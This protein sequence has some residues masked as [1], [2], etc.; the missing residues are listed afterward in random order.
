M[1]AHRGRRWVRDEDFVAKS[2]CRVVPPTILRHA[3]LRLPEA[4]THHLGG[5][6]GESVVE[7]V[8]EMLK[9]MDYARESRTRTAWR[10][11]GR[12]GQIW[13]MPVGGLAR[14]LNIE[15][16]PC[17]ITTSTQDDSCIP[18]GNSFS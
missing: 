8:V 11:E 16:R 5:L 17:R 14:R 18:S 6:G 12:Q 13:S 2:D 4:R 10:V 3:P 1:C 7:V 15:H 9:S